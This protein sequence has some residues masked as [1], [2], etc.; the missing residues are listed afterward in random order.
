MLDARD[1]M[2][3]AD[4]ARFG[5]ADLATMWAAFA[6]RG[7]GRD[8]AVTPDADSDEPTPSFASPLG[9]NSSVGLPRSG[10]RPDLCRRLRGARGPRSRTPTPATPLTDAA[11]FTPGTYKM[12]AVSPD[13]GFTRFTMVVPAG[14]GA[15]EVQH[16]DNSVNIA[17]A[18]AGRHGDRLDGGLAQR[19]RAHR[20][21]RGDQL[22][23]RHHRQRR[24]RSARRSPSTS[25]VTTTTVRRVNVS[26]YLRPA[27]APRR[28]RCRV[29]DE[30]PD[31]GSRFTALRQFALEA[32]VCVVRRGRRRL[33]AVLHLPC[34]RLP[35]RPTAAGGTD[36]EHAR[37]RR[38]GH[39][40]GCR[41]VRHAG[42]PGLGLR[43]IMPASSTT[44]RPTTRTARP[45]RTATRSC[46]PLSCRSSR[47]RPAAA[48]PAPATG[49]GTGR[50]RHDG[51]RRPNRVG[52]PAGTT[53]TVD[54]TSGT[55]ARVGT[56][57]RLRILRAARTTAGSG[58]RLVARLRLDGDRAD[59]LGHW[60]VTVDGRR[61]RAGPRRPADAEDA[62]VPA[63]RRRAGTGCGWPSGRRTARP[64]RRR[65]RRSPGSS[66]DAE[67][68]RPAAPPSAPL[69]PSGR[70]GGDAAGP[71]L[72]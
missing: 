55:P 68:R 65:D 26:A 58:P 62:A 46:T 3:A 12:L 48:A 22:G 66:Y 1:A 61:Q 52:R 8:G 71:R 4:Q 7:M 2:L 23:W 17:S 60:V 67:T 51:R 31:S 20:R 50:H 28:R 70:D 42:E 36:P 18:A 56:S 69:P 32:C 29:A 10:P 72:A 41:E 64:S 25:Q 6:R 33:V 9:A 37:V 14:G 39:R 49:A 44:T 57:V 45:T 35:Q 43:G 24:R 53:T 27:P 34:G 16:N 11:P 54:D 30:D 40:R 63:P 5:G 15:V 47:R 13:R 19:G 21:H 38:T 59:R